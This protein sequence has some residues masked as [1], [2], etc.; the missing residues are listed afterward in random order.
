MNKRI[1][2]LLL[3]AFMLLGT[4]SVL[5][6]CSPKNG[7]PDALVVMTDALDGVFNPFYST[8]APDATIVAMTQIAMLTTGYENGQVTVAC[9]DDEA[10]VVK[11]YAINYD[12]ASDTTTYTFV[13][14]NGIKFSDGEPLT[15]EDVLFNMYVYLDPVYTGSSTMYS[16]DIVGLADYR[17]QTKGSGSEDTSDVIAEL[18]GT[19]AKNRI[20]ELINL[21]KQVGKTDTAGSYSAD[22][23]TMVEAIKSAGLSKGYKEA[24]SN[25]YA[26]VTTD[27]L[28][29]DYELTLSE[30]KKELE[31][32]YV[33]A[34][35]SY[36]ETPYKETGEFDE[37]T[38][39]MFAEGF[40]TVEFEKDPVTNK[41]I[42]TK[43]KKVTRNYS[44]D[45]VTSKEKAIEYVYNQKIDQE[46]H[47][48]LQ[49]WAT[50]NTL[51]TEYSAQATSVILRE[52]M[53]EDGTLLVPNISGIVSLG[54]TTD[55]FEVE[56]NNGFYTVAHEHASDGTPANR[57]EYDV[58]QIT[59]NGV[60]P[61]AIWN[62]AFSVAPQHYYAQGYTVDVANNNFGVEYGSFDYMSDVIRASE[63][64]KVPVGAGPY[65]ATNRDNEDNPK[66]ADFYL[67][68]IVY[69]KANENF[70]M[71]TPKI[72]KLRYQVVSATNALDALEK[73]EVHFVT[74]QYTQ[75]NIERINNL[76]SRGI[77]S[78]YT[79]QLG[80]GYIGI[81]AGKVQDINLRRA[82]MCAMD[83]GLALEYYSTGTASTIYWPMSTV[84]WAYPMEN[85]NPSR[86]N[87]HEYPSINFNRETAKQSILD[88]MA[89]AGVSE[90][91]SRLSITFTIAGADLTDHPA[92]K[93][94]ESAQ[95]LLNEC[96]WD[97]EIVPDTQALTKL[98][99]GSLAVWA[100]AW[101]TTVDPDMYQVYHKNST[102]SSTLAWGYREILGSPA[103]YP[104]ENA[105]L[106]MLSEVI[107][108]ARETTD[109]EERAEL[110]KEAMGYVLD[111]AIEL[112]VYQ[113]KTLYAYN[114]RVIDSTSLPAEIN[115]YTSPLEHIWEIE[116]AN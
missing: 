25:D 29:A 26:S 81:N 83:T 47:I 69:F 115:P 11:D 84:S 10:V 109:Q 90:G 7:R 77:K 55:V 116:F 3:C 63:V 70:M 23:D 27:Q 98:S 2:S 65:K 114:A 15:I 22:Y 14:K 46:L 106:S 17:T 48:I 59:I 9:G 95:A 62:F 110:Y 67:N 104:E 91:D 97:I 76:G 1:L 112:P 38:S 108:L 94:F 39:F 103:S 68:N 33:S 36:T 35:V 5:S 102:A 66:G 6:A 92:Y 86:D 8:T 31:T 13:I 21:Y 74:P 60:D 54:H 71:G 12:D 34:S 105:I 89:A 18:A 100:A 41:D 32:D 58:L 82:I 19:R 87:G 51:R 73:G 20:N 57:E 49:Y 50:A 40:V 30:F 72:E 28:L 79:D 16:T 61:K 93:V 85:G 43:I 101:G 75:E 107:D 52:N 44:P 96:G 88:Y 53:S 111:L 78:T 80:Y 24:V 64:T 4:P 113:R 45:V 37:I 42:K 56:A 99:T